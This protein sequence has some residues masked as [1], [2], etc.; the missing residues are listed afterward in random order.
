MVMTPNY[1]EP[2]QE[3]NDVI[4]EFRIVAS[5]G[6]VTNNYKLTTFLKEKYRNLDE[7]NRMYV[8]MS[9]VGVRKMPLFLELMDNVSFTKLERLQI[10]IKA[11]FTK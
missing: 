10:Q 9:A 11:L 7:N 3:A 4:R 1:W 8:A 2:S 5:I 6:L